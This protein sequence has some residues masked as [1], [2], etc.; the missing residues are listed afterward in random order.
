M[1]FISIS[2]TISRRFV[3]NGL[4]TRIILC[5]AWIAREPKYGG[6]TFTILTRRR[7]FKRIISTRR[8]LA[9]LTI[10]LIPLDLNICHKADW[11]AMM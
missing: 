1:L 9:Y 10:T 8:F 2:I 4:Q 11:K 5:F 3:K 6:M 7:V